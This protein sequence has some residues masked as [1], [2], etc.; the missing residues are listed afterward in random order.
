MDCV[1][2]T[3]KNNRVLDL[4]ITREEDSSFISNYFVRDPGFSDH[5]AVHCTLDVP[6]P[7]V[8]YRVVSYRQLRKIKH[9]LFKRDI[10]NS[11][12]FLSPASDL[13]DLCDQ[14][15][16]VLRGILDLHAPLN[17]ALN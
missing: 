2:P 6:K 17:G 3:Y 16:S 15:D 9:D 14:Y 7:A 8:Q 12:L 13:S 4:V 10:V 5:Y 11:S 1:T